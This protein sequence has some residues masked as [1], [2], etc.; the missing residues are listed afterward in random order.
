MSGTCVDISRRFFLLQNP[1]NS[2]YVET[3]IHIAINTPMALSEYEVRK[4]KVE[5]LRSLGINPYAQKFDKK[6]MIKDLLQ[7][8]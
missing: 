7:K 3:F 8:E 1:H 6:Y 2:L 5:T 4:Q